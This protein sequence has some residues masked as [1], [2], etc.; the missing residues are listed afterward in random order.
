MTPYSLLLELQARRPTPTLDI[1]IRYCIRIGLKPLEN[2]STTEDF[3]DTSWEDLPLLA[4]SGPPNDSCPKDC[5]ACIRA[6]KARM[7]LKECHNRQ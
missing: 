4:A 5:R 7:L 2:Q 6:S 3:R 1:P